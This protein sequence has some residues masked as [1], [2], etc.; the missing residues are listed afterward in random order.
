MGNEERYEYYQH[1]QPLKKDKI[2]FIGIPCTV[3]YNFYE[4]YIQLRTFKVTQQLK[5]R[6][7]MIPYSMDVFLLLAFMW[8][9]FLQR[10]NFSKKKPRV[11]KIMGWKEI[12]MSF[13]ACRSRMTIIYQP[14]Q[15]A[16]YRFKI[17]ITTLINFQVSQIKA[18]VSAKEVF[19][20]NAIISLFC[21]IFNV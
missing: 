3:Y 19:R 8:H 15:L 13:F 14:L 21:I 7:D 12:I 11:I 6:V 17:L 4:F 16:K 2:N 20:K 10:F 1:Y 18:K 9:N 5:R